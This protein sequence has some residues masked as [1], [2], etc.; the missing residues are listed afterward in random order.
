MVQRGFHDARP[1]VVDGHGRRDVV[2]NAARTGANRVGHS[3]V[4]GAAAG[5]PDPAVGHV[6]DPVVSEVVL[7]RPDL[8]DDAA[9]PQLVE[10]RGEVVVAS[11]PQPGQQINVGPA[12]DDRQDLG[13]RAGVWG[14]VGEA[15]FDDGLHLAGRTSWP[16]V[17]SMSP[18]GQLDEEQ[19]V[20]VTGRKDPFE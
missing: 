6:A 7:V 3:S 18:L 17:G 2:E 12:T 4:Q 11:R 5:R 19:R 16:V 15:G 20:A 13:D 9:P 14:Q 8:D 10:C 1:F